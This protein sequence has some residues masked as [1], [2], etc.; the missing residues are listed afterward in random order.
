MYVVQSRSFLKETEKAIIVKL[1]GRGRSFW[2]PSISK[3]G[4][5]SAWAHSALATR[6]WVYLAAQSAT[7]DAI[8]VLRSCLESTVDLATHF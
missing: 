5:P 1:L 2:P 4:F 3:P 6:S 8:R 7:K